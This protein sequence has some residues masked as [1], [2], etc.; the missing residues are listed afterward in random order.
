MEHTSKQEEEEAKEE[1]E[2]KITTHQYLEGAISKRW[3]SSSFYV[4]LSPQK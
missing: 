3:H 2:E 1:E 4:F